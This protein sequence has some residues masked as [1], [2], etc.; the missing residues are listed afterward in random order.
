MPGAEAAGRPAWRS[1]TGPQQAG[2]Q[3]ARPGP[4]P[5]RATPPPPPAGPNGHGPSAMTPSGGAGAGLPPRGSR[6]RRSGRHA[7]SEPG[8]TPLPRRSPE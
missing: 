3:P 2:P 8:E 6:A 1:T 7:A 5:A 4:Q